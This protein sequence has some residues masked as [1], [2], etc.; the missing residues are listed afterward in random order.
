MGDFTTPPPPWKVQWIL[1]DRGEEDTSWSF[2]APLGASSPACNLEAVQEGA[3][4][5]LVPV[6]GSLH[7]CVKWKSSRSQEEENDHGGDDREDDM[8]VVLKKWISCPPFLTPFCHP[9]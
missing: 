9:Y 6:P 3:R 1:A 2:S 8:G 5:S 4:R 7:D